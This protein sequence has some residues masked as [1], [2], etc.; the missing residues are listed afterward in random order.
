MDKNKGEFPA[1]PLPL[2]NENIDE[3]VGGMTLRDYF[4]AKAMHA[5]MTRPGPLQIKDIDNAYR[6]ADR[7]IEAR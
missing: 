6:Y 5:L 3:S 1:F 4:A 2:G 7:M